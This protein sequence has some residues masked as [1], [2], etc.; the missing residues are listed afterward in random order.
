MWSGVDATEQTNEV[1]R[2][3][4]GTGECQH[5]SGVGGRIRKTWFGLKRPVVCRDCEGSGVCQMCRGLK[6]PPDND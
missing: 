3:C 2:L 1:C 4:G 5:C 6:H